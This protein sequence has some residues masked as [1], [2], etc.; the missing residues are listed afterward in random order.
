MSSISAFELNN[1]LEEYPEYEVVMSFRCKYALSE[2][3][4]KRGWISYINGVGIDHEH[5]EIKLMN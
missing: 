3:E 2:E 4:N 5:R 1:I